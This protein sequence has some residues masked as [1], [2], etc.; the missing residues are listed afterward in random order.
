[1]LLLSP[2]VDKEAP[3]KQRLP[4][5]DVTLLKKYQYTMKKIRRV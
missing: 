1:M 3:K 2:A 5:L 4:D